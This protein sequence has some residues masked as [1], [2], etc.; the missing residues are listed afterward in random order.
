M[1]AGGWGTV[2]VIGLMVG[3]AF[4]VVYARDYR[5]LGGTGWRSESP[6]ETLLLVLNFVAM[7]VLP[8]V[9]IYGHWLDA[10]D[11]WVPDPA[12]A[13]G[14][15]GFVGALTLLWHAHAALGNNWSPH[16]EV[17]ERQELVTDRIYARMQHPMYAAHLLWALSQPL[18][19]HNWIG[20]LSFLA[21]FAPLYV[22]RYAREERELEEHFG[23]RYRDWAERTGRLLPWAGRTRDDGGDRC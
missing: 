22:V 13:V 18:L 8:P 3:S 4:R 14:A 17:R 2:Y 21:L 16:T 7:A 23:D 6:A 20:G 11:Y 1:S 12:A 15:A 10:A 19:V 9:S 5:S